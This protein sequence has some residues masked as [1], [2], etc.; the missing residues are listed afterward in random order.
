M[1]LSEFTLRVIIRER[2]VFAYF[3]INLV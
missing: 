3:E 2:S 1:Q